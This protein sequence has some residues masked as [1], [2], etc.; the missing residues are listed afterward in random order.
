M[1]AD[2][3]CIMGVPPI[4]VP[5]FSLKWRWWTDGLS[6][7][8]TYSTLENQASH[9]GRNR[10]TKILCIQYSPLFLQKKSLFSYYYECFI[11]ILKEYC[12]VKGK[13]YLW[14][15]YCPIVY[16]HYPTIIGSDQE[17]LVIQVHMYI[18]ILILRLEEQNLKRFIV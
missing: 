15:E 11:T 2:P 5:L 6:L 13:M 8:D 10:F 16:H 9:L 1:R 4:N 12:G 14:I 17:R 3:L 18:H 7:F